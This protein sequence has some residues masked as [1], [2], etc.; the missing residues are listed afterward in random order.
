MGIDVSWYK[1]KKNNFSE[2]ANTNL[3]TLNTIIKNCKK[4][5]LHETRINTVFGEGSANAKV[6]IIGEAPGKDEDISGKPFV[7]RAGKL[8]TE[9]LS[10]INLE[11]ND[12]FIT[13][14]VKCR[15]PE[16][17]NPHDDEIKSCSGYLDEQI[18]LINPKV[19]VLLGKIAANRILNI[20]EP[21][22][23]LRGKKYFIKE[24][25]IPIIV[26]YHP[27]YLLRSPL[28]KSKVWED[29]K[30]MDNIITNHDC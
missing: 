8:L 12:I 20:D 26:F 24:N 18:K 7:G 29:L 13:N 4:C 3:Q 21:I 17:R 11:R 6:M 27:A 30:F 1:K 28:Q 16:N 23:N 5:K 2:P 25:N 14:T 15:P 22:S 19:I 9:I 10:S